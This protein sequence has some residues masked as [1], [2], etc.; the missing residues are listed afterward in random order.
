MNRNIKLIALPT[1]ADKLS[2]ELYRAMSKRFDNLWIVRLHKSKYTIR[3]ISEILEL[4]RGV[5]FRAI[6]KAKRLKH[7]KKYLDEK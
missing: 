7:V 4:S 3:E 2:A 6:T 5:V 1:D